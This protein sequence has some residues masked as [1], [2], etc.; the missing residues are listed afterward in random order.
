MFHRTLRPTRG[1]A[2]ALGAA[3]LLH[4]SAYAQEDESQ[5]LWAFGGTVFGVSQQAYPGSDQ[6]VTRRVVLPYAVYRGE[7]LRSDRSSAGVRAI[8]T[9]NTEL[10]IGAALSFG[11]GSDEIDARAGMKKLGTLIEVGPRLKVR[12]GNYGGGQLRFELPLRAVFDFGDGAKYS[13][14]TLEPRLAY[15]RQMS[16]RWSLSTSASVMYA[17]ERMS[18]YFYQVSD[19][20]VV[21]A[22]GS[23]P[24][25]KAY[26]ARAGQMVS[27]LSVSSS[28]N[29]G[30]DW[31]LL[32]YVRHDTVAGAANESSPLVRKTDG[33][34]VGLGVI[35]T[36]LRSNE[37][38][39]D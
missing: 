23:L 24:E 13:G 19:A 2:L 7:V 38:A 12:L 6:Q 25:R 9:P 34:T 28:V 20:D 1:L 29:L 3:A 11:G 30:R 39:R 8:K 14:L 15:S 35:Y 26:D 10:D 36:W 18:D 4:V 21:P 37:K 22:G 16:P 5:H 17:D 32:G 31:R 27:R 33:T